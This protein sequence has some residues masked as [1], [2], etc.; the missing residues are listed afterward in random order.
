MEERAVASLKTIDSTKKCTLK[1]GS[2]ARLRAGALTTLLVAAFA[3]LAA[4]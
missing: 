1:C 2:A 4:N 3:L